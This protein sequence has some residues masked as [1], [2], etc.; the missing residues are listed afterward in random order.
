MD[1]KV[2]FKEEKKP[3]IWKSYFKL[4]F[5]VKLP[6]FWIA[7]VTGLY[8]YSA[9]LQFLFPGYAQKILGG[10]ISRPV[11]FGAMAVLIGDT[12]LT[13]VIRVASKFTNF[14]IDRRFRM[15]FWRKLLHS[16]ISLFD[17]EKPNELV[18]RT[19]ADTASV[20]MFF[21]YILPSTIAM[22]SFTYAT[23]RELFKYDW[24]LG[25]GQLIYIPI[26]LVFSIL[27][28]KWQYKVNIVTQSKLSKLTQYLSELL[29]NIPLI[30]AFANEKKEDERGQKI[31][32]GFY[33]A[34]LIRGIADWAE[35][36]INGILSLIQTI[37]VL[38]SG[39]YLVSRKIISI[40]QW[41]AYYLYV[42]MM[43]AVL[44]SGIYN[45][46][47][48]KRSQGTTSRIA[49]LLEGD[50][51]EYIGTKPLEKV[52]KDIIFENVNFGYDEKQVLKD[53]NIKIPY[54]KTTAIIGE[55]GGGKTTILSLLL[56]FY[57]PKVGNIKMGNTS[58]DEF[59][60][61]EWRDVFSYVSQDSP[62]LSGS[63]RDNI[64]YGVDREVSDEE[65]FK[66]AD[67]ANAL[68]FIKEFP[69]GFNT[70]VGEGGSKL[71]GGQR[72]RVS[73]ARAILR[74][75]DILLLD[76][77]T[78]NLDNQAEKHIQDAMDRLLKDRTSIIIAHDLSTIKHADQIILLD[79]GR[80]NA[81]GTHDELINTSR[82]YQE[83]VESRN[84]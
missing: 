7:L 76:E 42:D 83:I 1:T 66:V 50:E 54:G 3:S 69:A 34:S 12:L 14:K 80:V 61:K 67:Q 46:I 43:Y 16:P 36:P 51:E 25:L 44:A 21:S 56:R 28:G 65:I 81:I 27:Y 32:H 18:S 33:R 58:I 47:D 75:S 60:L 74:N 72:Q 26:Y 20:S 82:L 48:I 77:P 13:A 15:V 11:V 22:F 41:V 79:S 71:S 73:I 30:K 2:E 40:N 55:S 45:Y 37:I 35:A 57:D 4:L 6:Y 52:N 53:I 23:I 62:L 38:L 17:R 49:E 63:I 78:A 39:I 59:N 5:K 24:R 19:T 9:R 31:I 29:I 64:A 10:D 68:E 84:K 8:I 70:E